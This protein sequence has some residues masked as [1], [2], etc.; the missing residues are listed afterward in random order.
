M[1]MTI[2][3]P[4][5]F[6]FIFICCS[7][8]VNFEALR[9]DILFQINWPGDPKIDVKTLA[10]PGIEYSLENS[11]EVT[12][13]NNEKYRCTI[14]SLTEESDAKN[15][16]E[17]ESNSIVKLLAPVLK[18]DVCTYNVESYWTYELCNGKHIRQYHE[19]RTKKGS[20]KSSDTYVV[21]KSKDGKLI[22]EPGDD[23]QQ[24]LIQTTEYF[25]GFFK[26]KVDAEGIMLEPINLPTSADQVPKKKINGVKTPYFAL[27]MTD[28]TPCDLKVRN[29]CFLLTKKTVAS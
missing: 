23:K 12:S 26:D 3:H 18:S 2:A 9:D 29:I 19:E 21:K 14:P 17:I 1:N 22:L 27:N 11:L 16:A 24:E 20:G 15:E 7:A 6:I 10:G 5:Q 28:G 4:F 25:L 8:A 13:L